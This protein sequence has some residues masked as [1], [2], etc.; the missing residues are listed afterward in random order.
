MILGPYSSLTWLQQSLYSIAN[1]FS[2]YGSLAWIQQALFYLLTGSGVFMTTDIPSISASFVPPPVY[3]SNITYYANPYVNQNISYSP[4]ALQITHLGQT[5]HEIAVLN[6]AYT[7]LAEMHPIMVGSIV[8][9]FTIGQ[10]VYALWQKAQAQQLEIATLKQKNTTL[11]STLLE[12]NNTM[13]TLMEE[14]LALLSDDPMDSEASQIQ[15]TLIHTLQERIALQQKRIASLEEKDRANAL[16]TTFLDNLT[17]EQEDKIL[18]LYSEY[19]KTQKKIDK[20]QI[21]D[22]QQQLAALQIKTESLQ[23]ENAQLKN[24]DNIEDLTSQMQ[25]LNISALIDTV[26]DESDIFVDKDILT[27]TYSAE[28]LKQSMSFK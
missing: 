18:F 27:Y 5:S 19:N 8:G 7:V 21:Y 20:R 22:L 28:A 23:S 17:H 3:D 15:Q 9:V 25:M 16:Y 1:T 6:P 11:S 13:M 12:L 4:S 26:V 2:S 24:N 14:K 10:G